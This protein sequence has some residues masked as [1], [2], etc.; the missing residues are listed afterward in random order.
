MTFQW[1]SLR[2]G[3]TDH[4]TLW[5]S[6]ALALG[7]LLAAWVRFV[8][9]PPVLCPFRVLTGVPCPTCGTTRAVFAWLHGHPLDAMRLNPIIGVTPFV[10]GP[11][12]VYAATVALGG[13][14]RLRVSLSPTAKRVGRAGAWVAILATWAFLIVDGR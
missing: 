9:W 13:W 6:V 4:E 14:P 2:P 8:E 7:I 12:L 3:E 1:R 5:A 10:L 11:Y